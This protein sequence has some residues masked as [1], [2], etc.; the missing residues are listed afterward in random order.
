MKKLTSKR[1]G[2]RF[3]LGLVALVG[4]VA[5]AAGCATQGPTAQQTACPD[6]KVV[7][8]DP[9]GELGS[10]VDSFVSRDHWIEH[11]CP[12]CQ[13]ALTTLIREGQYK[14]KCLHPEA[15]E[16]ALTAQR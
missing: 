4:L 2:T 11:Q 12:Y 3:G 8:L 13:N 10:R 16:G 7:L 5:L 6:C 9:A 14:T 1:T 15:V